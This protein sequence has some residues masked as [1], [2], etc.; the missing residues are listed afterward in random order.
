[1]MQATKTNKA[2]AVVHLKTLKSGGGTNISD[3]LDE[4]IL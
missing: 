2:R 3:A 1:M 4:A